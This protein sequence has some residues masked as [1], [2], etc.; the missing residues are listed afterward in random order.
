MPN[1]GLGGLA[2][3]TPIAALWDLLHA[4]HMQAAGELTWTSMGHIFEARYDLGPVTIGVDVRNGKIFKL[5]AN[6][7]YQGALF[8][9]IRVGQRVADAMRLEPRLYYNDMEES[10]SIRNC[11]GVTLDVPLIDPKPAWVSSCV[12][13]A[14]SVFAKEAFTGKGMDGEW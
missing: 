10:L 8:G 11:D 3:R 12:I 5:I 9:S 6:D 4:A 14:I 2:L 7:G 1:E 13:S